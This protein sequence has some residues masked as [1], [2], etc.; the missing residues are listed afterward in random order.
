MFESAHAAARQV[1]VLLGRQRHDGVLGATALVLKYGKTLSKIGKIET[2]VNPTPER[3][4][5][6]GKIFA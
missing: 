6:I 4:A 3:L 2:R 5:C 1:L